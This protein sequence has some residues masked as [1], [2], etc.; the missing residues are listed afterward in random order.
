MTDPLIMSGI[1]AAAVSVSTIIG[2]IFISRFTQK[3]KISESE[4]EILSKDEIEFR[5][6]IIEQLRQCHADC[7]IV[8]QENEELKR[9]MGNLHKKIMTLEHLN[10]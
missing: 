2:N 4:R 5:R 7:M 3:R 9:E 1:I 10:K 8:K 6:T